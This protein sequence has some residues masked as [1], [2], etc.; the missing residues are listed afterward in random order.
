MPSTRSYLEQ[1]HETRSGE[2][3]G[4]EPDVQEAKNEELHGGQTSAIAVEHPHA[5]P[6][7]PDHVQK[8]DECQ[9]SANDRRQYETA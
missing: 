8:T 2:N 9:R 5:S 1:R 7:V 6:A 4:R 3:D